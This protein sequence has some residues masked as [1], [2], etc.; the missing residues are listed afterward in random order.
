MTNSSPN[1]YAWSSAAVEADLSH[2][3]F[4]GRLCA[5]NGRSAAGDRN[6]SSRPFADGRHQTGRC[7]LDCL[8]QA[9]GKPIAIQTLI[10]KFDDP[11]AAIE[12]VTDQF[13]DE[14]SALNDAASA[15]EKLIAPFGTISA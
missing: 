6:E 5:A 11:Q 8:S 3:L 1:P 7:L 9:H 2:L 13:E 4:R 15:A 14:V 12:G 10:Q